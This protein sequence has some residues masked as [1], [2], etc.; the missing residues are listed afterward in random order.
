MLREQVLAIRAGAAAQV[1]MADAIL[2]ALDA[3]AQAQPTGAALCEHPPEA[4]MA[5]ARMGAP[6]AWRCACGQEGDR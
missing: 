2:R 4:R 1:A 6:D 3:P 5:A